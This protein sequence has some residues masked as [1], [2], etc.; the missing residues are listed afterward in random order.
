LVQDQQVEGVDAELAGALVEGV[1][2]LVVAVVADP[3]LRLD[4]DLVTGEVRPVD[5][6]ADLALV[7]VRGS[8]VDVAVADLQSG[9]H[10]VPGLGGGGL[11]DAEAERGHRDAVVEFEC[12]VH[13]HDAT[14]GSAGEGGPVGTWLARSTINAAGSCSSTGARDPEARDDWT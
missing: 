13:P 2:G 5:R 1:Q 3:D 11:E 10:G 7:Q 4:E 14:S 12:F 9:C 6:L 8:G